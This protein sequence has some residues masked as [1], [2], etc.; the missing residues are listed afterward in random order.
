MKRLVLTLAISLAFAFGGVAQSL[1][2]VAAWRRASITTLKTV[3][4]KAGPHS[5]AT[6]TAIVGN[7]PLAAWATIPMGW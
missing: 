4:F 3:P 6:A 5:M 2:Y 7:L 1:H